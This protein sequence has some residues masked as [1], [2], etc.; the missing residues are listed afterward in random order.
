[1]SYLGLDPRSVNPDSPRRAPTGSI[2]KQGSAGARWALVESPRG[3][4]RAHRALCTPSP[5]GSELGGEPTWRPSPWLA[6]WPCCSGTCSQ[7]AKSTPSA[8]L[9]SPPRSC[10]GSSS[11]PERQVSGASSGGWQ[12]YAA[13]EQRQREQQIAVHAETAYRQFVSQ[14]RSRARENHL[15]CIRSAAHS[16]GEPAPDGVRSRSTDGRG[17]RSD[18]SYEPLGVGIGIR[19]PERCA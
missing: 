17:T 16:C 1:M 6:N 10:A 18:R 7:R 3:W 5:S 4:W 11:L 9:R 2:C 14:G 13:A 19:C 15:T 12:V 8:D